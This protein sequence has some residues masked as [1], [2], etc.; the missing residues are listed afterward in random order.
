MEP[1]EKKPEYCAG[2]AFEN[3]PPCATGESDIDGT[4]EVEPQILATGLTEYPEESVSAGE[5]EF[6]ELEEGVR[7]LS[8]KTSKKD[9]WLAILSS[10]G[11]IGWIDGRVAFSLSF[12]SV[13]SGKEN[14][15]CGWK[16]YEFDILR[17]ADEWSDD[18]ARCG[19]KAFAFEL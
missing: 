1:C 2:K 7:F 6:D 9:I 3:A 15:C 17:S 8:L 19:D 11:S 18:G 5:D 10:S 16:K 12:E 14:S 4:K 13:A